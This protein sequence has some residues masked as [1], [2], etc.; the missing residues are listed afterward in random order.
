MDR[1]KYNFS[2][3][4]G[5]SGLLCQNDGDQGDTAQR[6]GAYYFLAKI[7]GITLGYRE[8][9]LL[10]DSFVK[11]LSLL[12]ENLP[13]GRFRRHA[14]KN[15]AWYSDRQF[16][17]D[18]KSILMIAMASFGFKDILLKSF[19]D[20]LS[21]FLFHQNTLNDDGV[22]DQIPDIMN[23]HELANIIRG[24]SLWPLYPV[25]I[26]LDSLFLADFYFRKKQPWDY[27]NMMALNVFY[28]V[29][30]YPTVPSRL[31]F[32]FYQKTDFLL[33]IKLYHKDFINGVPSLYD[34][35]VD[36][37]EV[38]KERSKLWGK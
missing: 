12:S 20:N 25:L 22:R 19:L 27:D 32:N 34:M 4:I 17:R 3:N 21:R 1:L 6:V 29:S 15:A 35:F 9:R 36:A 13:K 11:D 18:Q 30:K 31:A 33:R 8:D 26:F 24:L 7:L 38:L 23:P 16:S 10:A 5:A 37:N 28:A 14:N 2:K